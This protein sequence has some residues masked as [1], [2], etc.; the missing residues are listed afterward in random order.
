MPEHTPEEQQFI[1]DIVRSGDLRALES[2]L[3]NDPSLAQTGSEHIPV[4]P[5]LRNSGPCASLI[6]FAAIEHPKAIP[7]LASYGADLNLQI[8][9]N[10][11]P[12]N[13][14]LSDAI[15]TST[16][17]LL[18]HGADPNIPNKDGDT[19]L[20]IIAGTDHGES[21]ASMDAATLLLKFGGSLIS[22]NVF[23]SNPSDTAYYARNTR[24]LHLFHKYGADIQS[25]GAELAI[26]I[27]DDDFKTL[28]TLLRETGINTRYEAGETPLHIAATI[29]NLKITEYLIAHGADVN[30]RYREED[31]EGNISYGPMPIHLAVEKFHAETIR[32][33]IA[34]GADANAPYDSS[35]NY[36]YRSSLLG[37]A[38]EA[39]C[40]S[41]RDKAHKTIRIVLEQGAIFSP[42]IPHSLSSHQDALLKV[43]WLG[44]KEEVALLLEY[45]AGE[46]A[47]ILLRAMKLA[48]WDNGHGNLST[49][50]LAGQR[51]D[52]PLTLI[53]ILPHIGAT[54]AILFEDLLNLEINEA[55][56]VSGET[57]LLWE[58]RNVGVP[59]KFPPRDYDIDIRD[60][61][62]LLKH[63][64]DPNLRDREGNTPL[65]V[66][67]ERNLPEVIALLQQYGATD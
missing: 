9:G 65:S 44:K 59:L 29:G 12:L 8:K 16:E 52:P 1:W 56:E 10:S 38:L 3:K 32:L 23:G 67:R 66:A 18:Q 13:E 46:N 19:S 53:D 55:D 33:L 48:I 45:G 27:L 47:E 61:E 6:H 39:T 51:L 30:A 15:F 50:W 21:V 37:I 49:L 57:P 43:A 60:V 17:L 28:K 58:I 63:G 5:Q 4:L 14:V 35:E 7:L 31:A 41:N 34:H 36:F 64:V 25:A 20:H 54:V 26:A 24:I 11:T 2:A 22:L 40:E 42:Q 62:R